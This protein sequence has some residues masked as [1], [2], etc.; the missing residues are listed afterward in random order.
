MPPREDDFADGRRECEAL[1]CVGAHLL[2]VPVEAER[3]GEFQPARRGCG[4]VEL[5]GGLAKGEH[6][7]RLGTACR[8]TIIMLLRL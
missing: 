6:T 7:S 4:G 1:L 8:V 2:D 3:C 5:V